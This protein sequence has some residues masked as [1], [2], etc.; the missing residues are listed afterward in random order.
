MF[1]DAPDDGV[2][3]VSENE[4]TSLRL[5]QLFLEELPSASMDLARLL[6]YGNLP[7]SHLLNAG[8]RVLSNIDAATRNNLS[9]LMMERGLSNG[10][11]RDDATLEVL[12]SQSAAFSDARAIVFMA[13]SEAVSKDRVVKNLVMLNHAKEPVRRGILNEVEVITDRLTYRHSLEFTAEAVRAWGSLLIDAGSVNQYGQGRAAAKALSFALEHRSEPYSELV[14]ACFPLV[15]EQLRSGKESPG[16]RSFFFTDW[17]RCKTARKDVLRAYLHSDWP[18]I[19]L[20]KAVAPT[21]DLEK[22]FRNLLK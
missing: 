15:Y 19:D 16:L 5:E 12:L 3:K 14:V 20:L 4:K 18:A 7:V 11:D 1:R 8:M 2:R 9:R 22:V 13:L 21:G 10:S 6:L 17:D